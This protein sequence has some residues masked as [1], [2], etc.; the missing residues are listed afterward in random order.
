MQKA[1][2]V[3]SKI[4]RNTKLTPELQEEIVRFIEGG[5]YIE[6]TCHAVGVNKQTFYNWLQRGSNGEQPFLDFLDSIKK[7][8]AK[9]ETQ[10]VS[11]I[12]IA[13]IDNWQAAAWWLE[14]TNWKKWGKKDRLEVKTKKTIESKQVIEFR[15]EEKNLTSEQRIQLVR[16]TMKTIK[17]YSGTNGND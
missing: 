16:F 6:T 14:R 1:E 4:G 12:R 15:K 3:K 17:E 5:N 8:K 10:S 2:L 13:G 7:A 9:A 11:L